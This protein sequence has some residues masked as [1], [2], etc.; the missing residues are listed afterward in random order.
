MQA[1]QTKIQIINR[2]VKKIGVF[3]LL[4]LINLG[5][6][7]CNRYI[8]SSVQAEQTGTLLL[9][10][11]TSIG[12]TFTARFDGLSGIGL[13]IKQGE[14]SSGPGNGEIVLHLR[15]DPQATQDIRTVSLPLQKF[16]AMSS[17]RFFFLPLADS[18]LQD[19]YLLL[20]INGDSAA[21]IGM[22]GNDTYLDG[23][24]YQ[25]GTPQ[26]GQLTFNLKYDSI[27]LITGL[28]KEIPTW[29]VWLL[30][31]LFLFVLPGW[32]ILGTLWSGWGALD[33]WEKFS[34]GSGA[35]LAIYPVLFLWT[36][37]VGVHLG[38]FYAWLPAV[39]GLALLIWRN[40]QKA[41]SGLFKNKQASLPIGEAK[42]AD[43]TPVHRI[44]SHASYEEIAPKVAFIILSGAVIFSRLW[45][46]RGLDFPLWGDS[47]QHT[48]ISQLMVDNWG[49]FQSWLPYA[50]LRTF[51]YHFGFH[52][53]VAC[54]NWVIGLP[55]EKAILIVGQ[56]V[57]ILTVINLYPLVKKL[58]KNGWS[59][60]ML[61]LIAGLISPMP[62]SYV[63]WGR[64]TQLAGQAI[65]PVAIYFTWR[66][67]ESEKI[68]RRL[69]AC[70]W[71]ILGGLA[72][73]H[74]R[75]LIFMLFFYIAFFLMN[76]RSQRFFHLIK[77]TFWSGI[78]G[79]LI[80]LPWLISIA[81]Y[82]TIHDFVAQ[83]TTM[84]NQASRFLTEYNILGDPLEFFPSAVWIGLALAIVWALWRREKNF[85]MML[86]WWCLVFLAANPKW[87]GLPGTGVINNFAVKIGDYIP[88]GIVLSAFGARLVGSLQSSLPVWKKLSP[89]LK[90]PIQIIIPTLILIGVISL[91][92]L[93]A[94]QRIDDIKGDIYALVT[95]PDQRAANWIRSNTQPGDR[96]L[97]NSFFAYGGSLIAG[98][99]GG[100]WLPLLTT[101][102][103]TQPPLNYG[104]EEGLEP[105][106]TGLVNGL[107]ATI[108][109]SGLS[110][111]GVLNLLRERGINYIYIGQKQGRVNSPGPLLDID[112]LQKD[113]RFQ[114]VYRQDQ[115]WIFKI[116]Y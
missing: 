72:L 107:V 77:K 6:T 97:V 34:L 92:I 84:P 46:I 22:A 68:D 88:V 44:A 45:V 67:L 25:N 70:N 104:S 78:G 82:N 74:Y 57:N 48:M 16:A 75:V 33:F 15:N 49:L 59:G 29:L 41:R 89:K 109:Q 63:N 98:S 85:I 35:S 66:L 58:G 32:G 5:L 61:V 91:G 99:D 40:F 71:I 81:P 87:I 30:V 65:L 50:E 102:I 17:Y 112:F 24:V 38:P 110:D 90:L 95:R 47:Y 79:A 108:E 19:Y 103:N 64:Y 31:G 96:F 3:V 55:V 13:V 105:D 4:I 37:L 76:L 2:M 26:E 93:Q 1:H 56:I 18:N 11:Q 28:L 54:F 115:V 114:L 94:R 60:V 51:T 7:G 42:L 53:L 73:T 20:E 101:R 62:M 69:L 106:Y 23:S 12:Q 80:F 111:P 36:N 43:A 113:P 10:P 116:N 9:D 52:T 83:I 14:Q 100:W 21:Q 27:E 39:F 86:L 8:S